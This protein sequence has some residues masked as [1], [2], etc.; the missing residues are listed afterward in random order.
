[1]AIGLIASLVLM[2]LAT[3]MHYE[4]LRLLNRELPGL[5][6]PSRAKLMVVVCVAFVA[7][8]AEMLLYGIGFYAV[9]QLW[10]AGS[11]T[12]SDPITVATYFYFS[13]ESYTT[14]GYGD[15]VPHGALRLLAGMEALNGL[16][17]IGWSASYTFV[18][19]ERFWKDDI[20]SARDDQDPA[21]RE[22]HED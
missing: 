19:M 12:E 3:A 5:R 2:V 7:H 22:R 14:L 13:A 8:A 16:L 10:G 11:L 18:A 6:I 1:M 21:P 17:L 9:G 20:G 15:I 4:A